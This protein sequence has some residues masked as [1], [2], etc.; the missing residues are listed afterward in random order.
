MERFPAPDPRLYPGRT[1]RTFSGR[2]SDRH[3]ARVIASIG[4]GLQICGIFVFSTLDLN[5]SLMIVVLGSVLNGVGASMFQPANN[6][7]VMANAPPK[8]SR[9]Q[10]RLL[11]TMANIGMVCSFAVALFVA[12]ISIPRDIAF[13]IF[14]GTSVNLGSN[15][16]SAFVDGMHSA[17]LTSVSLL[18]VAFV[19]S[20]LRGKEARAM[21]Q[22]VAPGK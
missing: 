12:S 4:L 14:L 10:F 21:H 15:L 7:A 5:S 1:G 6:S 16:A 17:L 22:D 20:I 19:L 11:R 18:I 8:S 3:G 9:H 13:Q 2:L